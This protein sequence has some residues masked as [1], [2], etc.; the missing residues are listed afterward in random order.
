LDSELSVVFPLILFLFVVTIPFDILGVVIIILIAVNVCT[1]LAFIATPAVASGTYVVALDR[2]AQGIHAAASLNP[3]AAAA[4]SSANH[5]GISRLTQPF[6]LCNVDAA[7]GA[8]A[9]APTP[10][11]FV[12]NGR[13]PPHVVLMCC[14]DIAA[15]GVVLRPIAACCVVRGVALRGVICS[16]P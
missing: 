12:D 6:L 4:S 5:G 15:L 7:L 10:S 9:S 2:H 11:V 13:V 8:S 14:R 3:T 1:F 16:S